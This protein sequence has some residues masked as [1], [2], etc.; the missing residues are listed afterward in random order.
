MVTLTLPPLGGVVHE[1]F[2]SLPRGSETPA[3]TE[4]TQGDRPV[5]DASVEDVGVVGKHAEEAV[6]TG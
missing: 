1:G 5:L 2:E 3:A 6:E 4:K